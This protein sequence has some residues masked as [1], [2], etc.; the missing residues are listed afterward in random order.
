[1]RSSALELTATDH[2]EFAPRDGA[3]MQTA[4]GRRYWP[5]DPRPEDIFIDDIAAG[6]SRECRYAG[7]LRDDVEH[8][9][10]AEHVVLTSYLVPPEHAFPA[11]MHDS[12][13][14]YV[15]DLPRPVKVGMPEYRDLEARSWRA[16]AARFDLPLE[17]P[18]CVHNADIAMLFAER[19]VVLAPLVDPEAAR[20]WGMGLR[21]TL[22]ADPTQI[23]CLPPRAAR[24]AFLSRFH[25][26][27]ADWL[28]RRRTFLEGVTLGGPYG[29]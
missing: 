21:S 6:L 4:S 19:E 12:T 29:R 27:Y 24:E 22:R 17:L 1:M 28:A 18:E 14:A 3:W 2:A 26:L 8:Y 10:V 25:H 7:Q 16:I 13:E 15:K 20:E 9:S 5:L 11:L 23:I